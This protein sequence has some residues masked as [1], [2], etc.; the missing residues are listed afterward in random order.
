ML[1]DHQRGAVPPGGLHLFSNRST[2]LVVEESNDL[3]RG[4]RG[5][6]RCEP[7]ASRRLASV[8]LSENEALRKEGDRSGT[9]VNAKRAVQVNRR[10]YSDTNSARARA[11]VDLFGLEAVS[12][13]LRELRIENESSASCFHRDPSVVAW[14]PF[15]NSRELDSDGQQSALRESGSWLLRIGSEMHAASKYTCEK[16]GGRLESLDPASL[17]TRSSI[18]SLRDVYGKEAFCLP[19]HCILY[20]SPEKTHSSVILQYLL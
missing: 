8:A 20:D 1:P 11:S 14:V 6:I 16:G 12:R 19:C 17:A 2:R 10:G 9:R 13:Y 7:S 18:S 3:L 5:T 15:C 4:R